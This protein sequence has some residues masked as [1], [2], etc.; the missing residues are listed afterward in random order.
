[1]LYVLRALVTDKSYSS[2]LVLASNYM[3]DVFRNGINYDAI[4]FSHAT[5]MPG[6]WLESAVPARGRLKTYNAAILDTN[7]DCLVL[8]HQ[9]V[10]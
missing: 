9:N 8:A 3:D 7:I 6:A 2:I 10:S 5:N 4:T 1:M